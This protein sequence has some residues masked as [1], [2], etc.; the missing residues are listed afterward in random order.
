MVNPA[1]PARCG[2]RSCWAISG[3]KPASLIVAMVRIELSSP[4]GGGEPESFATINQPAALEYRDGYLYVTYNVLAGLG[5]S[6]RPSMFDKRG[7]LRAGPNGK[8]ARWSL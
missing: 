3:R 5:F 4:A 7:N 1:S 2:S 6:E 8:L